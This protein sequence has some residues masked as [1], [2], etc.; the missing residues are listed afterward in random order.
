MCYSDL[1]FVNDTS[2]RMEDE[3][4]NKKV[5]E[6]VKNIIEKLPVEQKRVLKMRYYFNMSFHEIAEDCNISINTALGRMRYALINLRKIIKQDGV[7]LS[8]N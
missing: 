6:D 2:I 7:V 8:V 5:L 4:I 3:F 1:D